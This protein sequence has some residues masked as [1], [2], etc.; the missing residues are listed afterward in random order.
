MTIKRIILIVLLLILMLIYNY[1]QI[2][3]FYTNNVKLSSNKLSKSLKITQISDFHSNG[4]INLNEL[5]KKIG[6]F[7]PDLIVITGDL[8]D[9]NTE[10][11]GLAI[12][13]LEE[14]KK[15]STN[16]YFV[17]G[18]HEASNSLSYELYNVL[19]ELDIKH[20]DFKV[21]KLTINGNNINIIGVPFYVYE[22]DFD[23]LYNKISERDYNLLLSHSPNKPINYINE[24]IDLILS[25]HTHGGQVR[26]PIIGGILSP[27]QGL[28]P[29]YDKGLYKIGNTTLYIDSGLGNSVLPIRMFNRVQISNIEVLP[30]K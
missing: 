26:L 22:D 25:G 20:M 13:V 2:S 28:L 11:L 8:I 3:K 24:N 29:K 1:I 21:K 18:N 7:E 14:S 17:S 23:L 9:K 10:D 30:E 27:G 19:R 16:V 4:Y 5:F 15:I 12:E 6:E